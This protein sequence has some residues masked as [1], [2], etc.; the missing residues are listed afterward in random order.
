MRRSQLSWLAAVRVMESWASEGESAFLNGSSESDGEWGK[1]GIVC[2]IGWQKR[3]WWRVNL[4][5]ESLS[6]WLAAVGLVESG[7]N[8]GK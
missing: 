4:V 3:Q 7:S 2:L 6:P 8:E 1:G 5:R